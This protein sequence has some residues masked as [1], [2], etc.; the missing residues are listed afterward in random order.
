MS[1]IFKKGKKI[2]SM[3][4]TMVLVVS[5]FSVSALA[6]DKPPESAGS[7]S[8]TSFRE[9][10]KEEQSSPIENANTVNSASMNEQL[11]N[12]RD[13]INK[14]SAT[15][16]NQ[17]QE[18]YETEDNGYYS[19]ADVINNSYAGVPAYVVHGQ[20]NNNYDDKDG[21]KFSVTTPGT[22]VIAGLWDG[23][24]Y[25]QG[26]ET[27]LYIGLYD[28]SHKEIASPTYYIE[29]DGSAILALDEYLTVGTYY[30]A[31]MLYD[32][33]AYPSR[34]VGKDYTFAMTYAPSSPSVSYQSHVESI[35]WQDWYSNGGTSGTSGRSLRLEAMRLSLGDDVDGGIEYQ[36]HVQNIGWQ[37]WVADGALSGTSGQSLRLEAIKIRLTGAIAKQYDIYYRVHAQNIGW[38]GWAK[39]GQSAGTAGYSYRL[40]AIEI[41]LV[42]KGGA[43]PGS[44]AMPFKSDNPNDQPDEPA[45]EVNVPATEH[46]VRYQTH[47]QDVGW[48]GWK[49][50][51]EMAGTSGKSLR[52]EG[53]NIEIEGVN[54]AIEYRTHVQNIGWQ[55]WV[56]DGAMT[57]TSGRSLRLEAI[58]IRLTGDM[59]SKYDV[60]YRVHAQNIGWMGWAKNGQSAG[61]AG[62]SYRLEA[63][64]IV[65]V[66]KGGAA[67]GSTA[68]AFL[69][70]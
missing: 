63:I 10:L 30:V 6:A 44:T 67:P 41:K 37:D 33:A 66:D 50:N 23:D 53:M 36:T 59:A 52:L 68:N 45:P 7:Q 29:D 56:R 35:G 2:L 64:Q 38:M 13:S 24:L 58:D 57:G 62:F 16:A 34:F 43:A 26:L 55:D 60:Y 11:S 70:N 25:D 42:R 47:V 21:Y 51:G 19:T 69:Q 22:V 12:A 5:V 8:P 40:E 18:F 9:V 28:A 61:T 4:M 32:D 39:N 20:I 54:N 48:Q 46:A 65:L 17:I 3:V 14:T 31:A 1:R 15:S 27:E 49:R